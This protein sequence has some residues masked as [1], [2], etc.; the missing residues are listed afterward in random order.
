M[1]AMTV[2]TKTQRYAGAKNRIRIALFTNSV[3]VGGLEAHVALLA[4]HL[5]RQDFEVFAVYPKWAATDSFFQ[6]LE[7]VADHTAVITP[8]RRHGFV[9]QIIET[10]KLARQ[11]RLW[12]IEVFH[13]HSTTYRGQIFAS[14]AARVAGVRR[15]YVTEHLAPERTLPVRERVLRNLFSRMVDGIV[16]VSEKNYEARKE[17]TYTPDDQTIVVNNGVDLDD[18]P[19]IAPEKLH[20]LRTHHAIPADAQI[21][22][23]AI[24]FEA[25]KGVDYLIAAIPAVR[26][27]CPDTYFL[28]VGDGKLR[29]ELEAQVAILDMTEY[30]RFVGFQSDPRPYL[31]LMDAFVLPVPVGS[32]SIGLL[33]A[34]AME[35]A[36]VITF[37][38]TGE[39]VVHSESG[40]CAEPR[41]PA[42]I[43][44]YVSQI[45]QNPNLQKMLGRAARRRVEQEFSAQ[46]V[47]RVLGAVYRSG[48]RQTKG[49]L[50]EQS[51]LLTRVHEQ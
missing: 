27:A 15:I 7:A 4:R 36:V 32:M 50:A 26:A 11:L 38:G 37:G 22:G 47:A 17:H 6:S 16:C 34:M 24:R 23:T 14:L 10:I 42:S 49:L 30:V 29:K 3:A 12:R 35:R 1:R 41:D 45:L 31:G 33:E 19:P 43:A 44:Y 20:E 5:D 25:E 28:M 8:D 46:R 39:A 13:M 9:R 40:F 2:P 51:A 18:F 21:V 48:I